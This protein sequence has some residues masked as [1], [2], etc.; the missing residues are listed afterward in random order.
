MRATQIIGGVRFLLV[1]AVVGLTSAT[2]AI[3][4]AT[5]TWTGAGA[6]GNW[7]TA[8]NWGGTVPVAGDDLVF[9]NGAA[10]LTN[11]NDLTAGTSFNSISFTGPVG[12]Y[13]ISGNSI[14]LVAGLTADNAAPNP[15]SFSVPITLTASQTFTVSGNRLQLGAI[16]LGS[17]TLTLAGATGL[18]ELNGVVSGTGGISSSVG[19]AFV[20]TSASYTGPTTITGGAFVVGGASLSPSSVVTVNGGFLQFANGGSTGPITV[21]SPAQLTCQGGGVS[22][23][24]NVTDLTMQS[25]SKLEM[26]MYS[27][28]DYGQLNASGN[29][30]LGNATLNLSWSF[31]SATGNTFTIINKTSAGAI[32][33]T[34]NG[35]PEGATFAGGA[36]TYQITYIGGDGNDVVVTDITAPGPTPTPTPTPTATPTPTPTVTPTPTPG[37][38]I[39]TTSGGGAIAF[40]VLLAAA[41]VLLLR[42][43]AS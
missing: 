5:R 10:Q 2:E 24:G 43:Y 17:H 18:V 9:P 39:P 1:V 35:L 27:L 40:V 7:S 26:A 22:Q 25:G 16:D 34:F 19:V 38:N 21:N 14:A 4:A 23:I 30:S 28:S 31:T 13:T 8:A 3:F 29:V 6:N 33:G 32:T 12:G 20:N 41:G 37:P 15:N 11:T 36:R 42:R